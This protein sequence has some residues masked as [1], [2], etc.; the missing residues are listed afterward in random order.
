MKF[1]AECRRIVDVSCNGRLCQER[2]GTEM[3]E[4]DRTKGQDDE[5]K[6]AVAAAKAGDEAGFVGLIER[7]RRELQLHCYRMLGNFEESEDMVQETLLR[8]WRRRASFEGRSSLRAW[9]YRIATNACLDVLRQRP[10]RV[11]HDDAILAGN[12]AAGA[13]AEIPWLQPYPDRLLEEVA[14]PEAQPDVVVTARETVELTFMVAIQ[15]LPPLQRAALILRDVLGWSAKETAAML[16]TSVAAAN[17]ALQ[18]ARTT[19]HDQLPA[20][21]TEWGPATEPSTQERQL[22]QRYMDAHERAD[23]G[24][25]V[26][27]LHEQARFTMP[28]EPTLYDGRDAVAE[29]FEHAFGE[30]RPGEFRLVPTYANRMPAAANYIRRP[31][32]DTYR[33]M[34][35]DVL[36]FADGRLAEITTFVPELFPA[37]G[38]PPTL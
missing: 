24:A 29:F 12:A 38:L 18:R 5:R 13:P 25:V 6:A 23:S 16:E 28:P 22:L 11:V 20:Q 34:S 30:G 32:D 37:F 27:M 8:A 26:A 31:G 9:L 33:A 2:R 7:Y 14:S 10:R 15:H 36:R 4:L 35:L 17:S 3:S 1:R 19:V 21:R